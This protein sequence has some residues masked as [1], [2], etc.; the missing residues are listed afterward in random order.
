A[1]SRDGD[2]VIALPARG[3][4]V[5]N[6]TTSDGSTAVRVPQTTAS[7]N[8]AAVITAR[9]ERGDIVIDDLR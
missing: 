4:Y 8:A 3:A 5:V 6:A 1:R 2:V 9:S 7:E